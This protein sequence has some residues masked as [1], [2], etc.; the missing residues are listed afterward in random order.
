MS[1]LRNAG[2]LR[3][4][5]VVLPVGNITA[6]AATKEASNSSKR[7]RLATHELPEKL[8]PYWVGGPG[9]GVNSLVAV[10]PLSSHSL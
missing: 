5:A 9:L 10:P 3:P 7:L 1:C 6:N 8:A 2:K 4:G